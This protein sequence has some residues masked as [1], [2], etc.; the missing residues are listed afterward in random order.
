MPPP[1]FDTKQ[2]L[3]KQDAERQK[4]RRNAVTRQMRFRARH[5]RSTGS[6]YNGTRLS[7]VP[8]ARIETRRAVMQILVSQIQELEKA[9]V[10]LIEARKTK[11]KRTAMRGQIFTRL[12][13]VRILNEQVFALLEAEQEI[14]VA[15]RAGQKLNHKRVDPARRYL[16]NTELSM[17]TKELRRWALPLEPGDQSV[18]YDFACAATG[19]KFDPKVVVRKEVRRRA[20]ELVAE[21]ECERDIMR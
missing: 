11:S 2:R 20:L 13:I 8:R 14:A 17:L 15:S 21:A 10:A 1:D 3:R 4:K 16:D 5:G 19:E 6:G 18:L 9:E 7:K 12:E